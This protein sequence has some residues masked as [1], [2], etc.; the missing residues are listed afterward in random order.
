MREESMNLRN[1]IALVTEHNPQSKLFMDYLHV[2]IGCPVSILSPSSKEAK[3]ED[4]VSVVLIDVEYVNESC[5][6]KWRELLFGHDKICI[7]ALNLRDEKHAVEHLSHTHFSGIFYRDDPLDMICKGIG[8]LL[9][10]SVWMSRSLMAHL[11]E[12]FRK[13]SLNSYRP[14][15]GLTQREI[16]IIGLLGSGASN[17]QIAERLFV[18]EHT[19]KS[20]LYNTFKKIN[21]NNRTQAVNWARQN[22]GAPPPITHFQ[23]R[24]GANV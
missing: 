13:Q 16:E 6:H 12:L 3:F 17:T 10:G 4:N 20:H 9:E 11:I 7:A 5:M 18:S 22:L 19:V 23:H 14:A 15:C 8:R 1:G 24:R 2:N 21:V